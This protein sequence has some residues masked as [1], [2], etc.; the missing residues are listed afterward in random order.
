MGEKRNSY[1]ILVGMP[2][3]KRPLGRRRRRWVDTIKMYLREVGWDG[4][5]WI[6]VAEDRYR[7]LFLF[8][9]RNNAG[10]I[11]TRQV[12][13]EQTSDSSATV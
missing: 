12:V 6:D 2:E 5:D 7:Y 10:L 11:E 4:M 8:L 13:S 9:E 1:R 3:R